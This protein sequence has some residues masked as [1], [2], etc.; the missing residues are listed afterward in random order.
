MLQRRFRST[1]TDRSGVLLPGQHGVVWDLKVQKPICELDRSRSGGRSSGSS[2]A[3]GNSAAES[4]PACVDF[5]SEEAPTFDVARLLLLRTVEVGCEQQPVPERYREAWRKAGHCVPPD[6]L[7]IEGATKEQ[8]SGAGGYYPPDHVA[9]KL[10]RALASGDAQLLRAD[11]DSRWRLRFFEPHVVRPGRSVVPIATP[12]TRSEPRRDATM[13]LRRVM[14]GTEPWLAVE[15]LIR[16]GLALTP[17][18]VPSAAGEATGTR[19]LRRH[20]LTKPVD[21]HSWRRA[22][23]Q[24]L[25]DANVSAQQAQALAGHASLDAHQRYLN[26][27]AKMREVPAAALPNLRVLPCAVPKLGGAKA[28]R[29]GATKEKSPEFLARGFQLRGGDSSDVPRGFLD[30]SGG[31]CRLAVGF[32]VSGLETSL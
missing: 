25:A 26:N 15:T 6:G 30:D 14:R 22:Y 7:L 29:R 19:A 21:F 28:L 2:E 16:G 32:V 31:P 9:V 4:G 8:L 13:A 23:S 27:T 18:A 10:V 24:A 17:F 20:P 5:A 1:T 11:A 3:S 12:L